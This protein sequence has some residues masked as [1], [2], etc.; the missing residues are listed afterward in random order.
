M[1]GVQLTDEKPLPPR[2]TDDPNRL[3]EMKIKTATQPG[4]IQTAAK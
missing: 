3:M 2:K 1:H 4:T